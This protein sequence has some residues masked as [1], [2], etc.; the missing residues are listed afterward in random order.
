MLIRESSGRAREP[1]RLPEIFGLSRRE[2]DREREKDGARECVYVYIHKK[3]RERERERERE[4]GEAAP[5]PILYVKV[6]VRRTCRRA[7]SR[8][9]IVGVEE[10]L[11]RACERARSL[12]MDWP[13]TSESAEW[14]V[15]CA[16]AFR[17]KVHERIYT[18]LMLLLLLL[19]L[20]LR[21]YGH[22]RVD[23]L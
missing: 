10:Q 5:G 8:K 22:E 7:G 2:K 18:L 1:A 6:R 4:R 9:E 12:L 17:Q 16:I 23:V 11:A 13:S 3:Q 14:L 19:L 15:V 20:L 21:L